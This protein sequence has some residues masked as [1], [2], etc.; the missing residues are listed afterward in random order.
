LATGG[1]GF[2]GIYLIS[3]VVTNCCNVIN[4]EIK[5]FTNGKSMD[6]KFTALVL[7]EIFDKFFYEFNPEYVVNFAANSEAFEVNTVCTENILKLLMIQ[8]LCASSF[9]LL[10]SM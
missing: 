1:A 4:Y 7:K 9:L 8:N 6:L 2:I 3:Q 5:K 10:R